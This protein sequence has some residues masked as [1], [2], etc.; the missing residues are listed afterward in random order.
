MANFGST[1]VEAYLQGQQNR[2]RREAISARNLQEQ[3]ELKLRQQQVADQ[4]R[5]FNEQ[6]KLK[7]DEF[8]AETQLRSA[9]FK[10]RETV[11]K[12]MQ[13]ARA[14][15]IQAKG[16]GTV[17]K[18]AEGNFQINAFNTPQ[19]VGQA[20]ATIQQPILEAQAAKQIAVQ[21]NANTNA[22]KL[23]EARQTN[24]EDLAKVNNDAAMGRAQLASNARIKG[25]EIAASSRILAA[26]TAK[27]AKDFASNPLAVEADLAAVKEGTLTFQTL[28]DLGTQPVQKKALYDAARSK[29]LKILSSQ[30][31]KDMANLADFGFV[32]DLSK[33]YA[34]AIKDRNKS[35]MV[36]LSG[37]IEAILGKLANIVGNEKGVLTLAD[38]NRQR[39]FVPSAWGSIGLPVNNE[40]RLRDMRRLYEDKV[41]KAFVGMGEEQRMYVR[42][43]YGLLMPE[44]PSGAPNKIPKE[45][46]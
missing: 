21:D 36:T 20:Q 40:K 45:Q 42:K 37:Q 17:E 18:D 26:K 34:Q 13:A 27:E 15:E 23:E 46:K 7:Q 6:L 10:L 14:A 2:Q 43:T 11:A 28:K 19:E 9:D 44:L 3:E 30:D 31:V 12:Q 22:V 5:Q 33:Q 35:M 41:S 16:M 4:N 25:A 8:K 32:Y 29:G 39:G 1:V 24:R 38:I